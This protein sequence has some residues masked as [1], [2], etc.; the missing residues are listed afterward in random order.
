LARKE[1]RSAQLSKLLFI[2]VASK[3]FCCHNN[4]TA[5]SNSKTV[6]TDTNNIHMQLT[7]GST[8]QSQ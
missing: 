6:S 7:E 3:E 5:A 2:T 8:P 4:I 1:H